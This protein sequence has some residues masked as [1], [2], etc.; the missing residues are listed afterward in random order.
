MILA[1]DIGNTHVCVG[2]LDGLETKNMYRL[3]TN[4]GRTEAE[5]AVL[6]H[7]LIT[8]TGMGNVRYE[9]AILSSVVPQLTGVLYNAVKIVTGC[10]PIV[11]GPGVKTGLNIRID[12]PSS[13]GAD[14]VVGSVA[15]LH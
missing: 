13:M 4:I 1:V 7:Q 6:M 15:F 11:V 12:D 8:L 2:S 14:F 3:Q 10:E 9:G 5:Y